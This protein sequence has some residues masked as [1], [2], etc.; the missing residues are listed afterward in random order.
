MDITATVPPSTDLVSDPETQYGDHLRPMSLQKLQRRVRDLCVEYDL[1]VPEDAAVVAIV[2]ATLQARALYLTAALEE[3][4]QTQ[5]DVFL[6]SF[7][8]I[9]L[10]RGDSPFG[11]QLAFGA[12]LDAG[13]RRVPDNSILHHVEQS[14][15][16]IGGG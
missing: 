4:G 13:D 11:W 12:V 16:L 8:M 9:F 6:D 15:H 7:S 5:L 1:E 2:E 3:P 14:G 10:F